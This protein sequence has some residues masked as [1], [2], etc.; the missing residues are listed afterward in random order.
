MRLARFATPLATAPAVRP[1]LRVLLAAGAL[2][3]GA[4]AASTAGARVLPEVDALRGVPAS[5]GTVATAPDTKRADTAVQVDPRQG[6]P[7]FLWGADAT[8][9]L[10]LQGRATSL[11]AGL[12]DAARARAHLADLASLYKI[13]PAEVAALRVANLQ[14]MGNGDALVRLGGRVEGI[15]VFREQATVLLDRDGNLIAIGGFVAGAPEGV[16]RAADAYALTLADALAVALGDFDFP[17]SV[18]K[19]FALAA[20]D[21]GYTRLSLPADAVAG[22]A[23]TLAAP[24]RGKRVWFREGAVLVPAYYIEVQVRDGTTRGP[25]DF[26]AYVIAADDGRLLYRHNQTSHAA[27]SYRVYAEGTGANLPLPGPQ[28]RN[29]FPHPTG[30]PD[31]YQAP[32]VAPSLVALQN[33]PFSRNDP[34]LPDGATHTIG[35]NVEAYADV[36]DPDGFGPA[37][38]NECNGALPVAGDLHACTNAGDA[39]DYVYDTNLAPT[40]NRAQVMAAVTNLFYVTNYLHDWFYD[41]GFDEASGNAQASNFDRGGR[42][43]DSMM[44]EAQDYSGANNASMSTPSDGQR[45]QMHMFLWSSST[46]LVNVIA[47]PAIAG[48]K[49]AGTAVFGPQ[50]F[51]VTGPLV[52]ALDDA[53]A[54]GPTT[55]DGCSPFTNA[56]AVAGKIAAIDRGV[57]TFV[58]KVRNAQA[59][60]ATA[61]LILNNAAGGISMAGDDPTIGIPVLAVSL[62]DGNAIK[63]QLAIP[64]PVSVRLAR[65]SAVQRDG[66]LDNSLIAHEWG[67]YISNRLIADANGLVANQAQG[68]GEGWAD[69][70]ALLLLV[71][72]G[73][74]LLPANANFNGTYAETAFPLAGPDFGV[75]ARNNA[76][77]FGIRRFPYSRDM[78]KNPLTFR[79][80]TDGVALPATAPRS[81]GN[82]S[83][84][85]SEVHN[86]G[87]VWAQMLWECY[88]NLLNDTARL[89]FAQAQ[90]RM[91]RYLV[92]GY[93]MTP[94]N[95]TFV[96]ARDALLAVMLAQDPADHAAC[97]AGFAKR[98][99]GVGAIAPDSLSLDN[100][101]VVE[102]YVATAVPGG[103]TRPAVEYYHAAFDHYF[104]TD[105]PDEI[106][107]LDNGTFA[108]WARTGE[109]F[110]VQTGTPAGSATVCR[111]FSTAFGL[112]S[113][114]FY[115]PD[116]PECALVK[117]NPKWQFEGDVFALPVPA[118]NGTCAPGM[119]PVYRL[120]NDGKDGAPNHRYTTSPATRTQ[121]LGLGWIAEGY[122]DLGVIMCSPP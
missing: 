122:G 9:A 67:H 38:P 80:I 96:S 27:F 21:G 120:Y 49:G 116:V 6:V 121:M 98:G 114:H 82:G 34:W 115:T 108:G 74:R 97:L 40:A 102:S 110:N 56:A 45:P 91:K 90:D 60:G 64:T 99:L 24:A 70:H 10:A 104:V 23:S 107:K 22:H 52:Q 55:S 7:T 44:A 105:I 117:T 77:Y 28:G 106:A 26:Y 85:N 81:P 101:G 18:A 16:R 87:E 69:F 46:A 30:T 11:K 112:R 57:C 92:A 65:Q 84:Q 54:A 79:H 50:S 43:G 109:S 25:A 93:K 119:L 51:D 95:P 12:D 100:A 111:Y 71:K 83:A 14:R 68:L 75:D 15:E 118:G 94:F 63:A 20:A 89:T 36:A 66:A 37:D 4:F 31:G 41:A 19:R 86:T 1:R 35:N 58:V 8:R 73:D 5:R 47:P 39:F 72:E 113:S 61:V 17:R 3:A 78:A 103:T 76:Y 13:T 62:T 2:V 88:G 32:L 48:S 33:A 53:D 42:A 29:G 59:A